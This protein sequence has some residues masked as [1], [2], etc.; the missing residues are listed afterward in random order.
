M[1][2]LEPLL[3]RADAS[4]EIGTGHVMRCM[5]LAQA[6][7]DVGGRA[8][9]L[10]ATQ[11]GAL[12]ERL[13]AE[14]MEV[15]PLSALA[16]GNDDAGQAIEVARAVRANWVVVDGYHFSLQYQQTLKQ[17]GLSLLYIDDA[18]YVGEYFADTVLN[19]NASANEKMYVNRQ[20]YT[21]LLLGPRYALL[22]REF[23]EWC[24]WRRPIKPSVT[25][26]LVTL[27]GSDPDNITLTILRALQRLPRHDLAVKVICGPA[28]IHKESLQFEMDPAYGQFELIESTPKMPEL[29]VWADLVVTAG[30]S[31]CWEL[32]FLGVPMLVVVLADNQQAIADVLHAGR[33]AENLGWHA[34]VSEDAIAREIE[35]LMADAGRRGE[36]SVNGQQLVDGRGASRV[37][38]EMK[39]RRT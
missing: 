11:V 23:V 3:I 34:G 12:V 24:G 28:N 31:T 14:G 29:M 27:G 10:T 7:M 25:N 15:V 21:Q 32:A 36:M 6:W 4:A 1:K 16:G 5:A 9:F 2:P 37:V 30:G 17:A 19:Q 18:G 8:V 33:V 35:R 39:E 22:R 13:K 20:S 26:I 38:S